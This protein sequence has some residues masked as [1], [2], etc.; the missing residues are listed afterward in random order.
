MYMN[1]HS[2]SLKN[3]ALGEKKTKQ[4]QAALDEV[5]ALY[6]DF[7]KKRACKA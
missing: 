7:E 2:K 6:T 3:P 1:W 4:A 5:K